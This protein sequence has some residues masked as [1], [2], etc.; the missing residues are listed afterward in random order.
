M[1]VS[2]T[3]SAFLQTDLGR[4]IP[5][6]DIDLVRA[7]VDC[8]SEQL[9]LFT[10]LSNIDSIDPTA[11]WSQMQR[12]VADLYAIS[13]GQALVHNSR[14]NIDIVFLDFCAY[15]PEDMAPFS[16]SKTLV[17]SKDK[18][19]IPTWW[20]SAMV[21]NLVVCTQFSS[22][23]EPSN[24]Y[25]NQRSSAPFPPTRRPIPW[26][27]FSHVALGGTFDHLHVGHK[28][29]LTAAA[30]AATK[31]V[32]CGISTDTL[33][34]NKKYREQLESYRTRELSVL[35]FLR[36]IRKDLIFELVPIDDPYGPT[37]TD[38]S[39]GALAVSHETLYASNALNL[40]RAEHKMPP[41]ALL[42]IDLVVSPAVDS[43][44]S[45][46]S[47]TANGIRASV[48]NENSALKISSTDIRASLAEKQN[49]R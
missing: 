15:S 32:V 43:D 34:E 31:R 26:T 1:D 12:R 36:K 6:D 37:A 17:A 22:S 16:L 28:I 4:S 42:P 33:L 44:G 49:R 10:T 20:P 5:Q 29:L 35:L 19:A 2:P 21:Q 45:H 48:S 46:S 24:G 23:P 11:G 7:A 8:T 18:H 9:T 40:R 38:A 14:V 41:M 27:S 3:H 39:I 47:S 13:F 30:L 25:P